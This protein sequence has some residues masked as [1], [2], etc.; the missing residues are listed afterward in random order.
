M[1]TGDP[2]TLNIWDQRMFTRQLAVEFGGGVVTS[3]GTAYFAIG[4]GPPNPT[5]KVNIR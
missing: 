1:K 2:N 4:C 3:D 5:A